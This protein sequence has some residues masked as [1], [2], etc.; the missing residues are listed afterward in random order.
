MSTDTGENLLNPA[1]TRT[2]T[3][4]S[5]SSRP[6]SSAPSRSTARSSASRSRRPTTTTASGANE[7]PPAIISIFLGDQLNDVFEQIEKGGAKSSK[8]GGVFETGVSVLP[9]AAQGSRRPQPHLAVRVHRQQVRVPRR[10][11]LGQHRRRQ[12][13]AQ[14][15]RRRVARLHRHQARGRRQGRQ[16]LQQGDPG[17]APR[18]IK[19]SKKVVFNGN[20]YADEWH[21][22]AEK[23]G[24]PN[25]KNTVE[26]LPVI[27]R[28][29][30]I[31]LFSKYKVYSPRSSRA[32][33]TSSPRR[34]SRRSTSRR[35][36]R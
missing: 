31:D 4:S 17:A 22:E 1:T 19:E 26:V 12:H 9:A 28:K 14:H 18:I 23:R 35:T 16:G 10:R 11:Q 24:L 25:L 15:D 27:T 20:N 32:A 5:W 2:T 8:Q 30:T 33:S 3:R 36:P 21:Q 29:D 34:T 6:P 13:G 7:A